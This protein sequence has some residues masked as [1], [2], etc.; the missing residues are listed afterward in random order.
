[1]PSTTSLLYTTCSRG[2]WASSWRLASKVSHQAKN[3][4]KA[5]KERLCR[6][7]Q[8]TNSRGQIVHQGSDF[9]TVEEVCACRRHAVLPRFLLRYLQVLTGPW[10]RKQ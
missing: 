2:R 5:Q 1:M 9:F 7:H 3:S 8:G 6:K 10:I 4:A